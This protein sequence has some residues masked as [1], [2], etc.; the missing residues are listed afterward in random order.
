MNEDELNMSAKYISPLGKLLRKFRIDTGMSLSDMA[1][2]I[3]IT[4][5]YLSASELGKK[6]LSDR[7][8]DLLLEKYGDTYNK[9][10]ELKNARLVSYLE[11][12]HRETSLIDDDQMDKIKN[13][14]N[15]EG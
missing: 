11:R 7:V 15:P 1:D 8:F 5:S 13:A 14:L 9:T 12:V 10:E 3:G 4:K 6:D 2:N